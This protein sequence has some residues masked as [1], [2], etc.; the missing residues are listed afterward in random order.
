[1]KRWQVWRSKEAVK[2]AH[3]LTGMLILFL[4][5]CSASP[6]AQPVPTATPTVAPTAVPTP[7]LAPTPTSIPPFLPPL[8]V[9]SVDNAS[10]VQLLQTLPIPDF[11]SASVSQCSVAFNPDGSLLAGVCNNSTV[12]VWEVDS[13]RLRVTL[14][15]EPSHEVGIAFSPDGSQVATGGFGGE[16]RLFD[17]ASGELLATFPALR[18]PVWDLDFT[19]DG[20]WLAAANFFDAMYLWQ[21]GSG[22]QRWSYGTDVTNL[23]PLSV[24]VHPSGSPIAYG[25]AMD[26]VFILDGETGAVLHRLQ[27]IVPFGDVAFSPDGSLLAGGSD[28]DRIRL[29]S[30]DH[31]EPVATWTGHRRWVNGVAFSPDGSL[32]VSGSHDYTVGIWEV[33]TGEALNMLAG[34]E[35]VV[36]RVAVNPAGTL[37]ASI[38]WDGTVRLWGVPGE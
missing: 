36:L 27:I 18:S 32:L 29:W 9:I 35:T 19:P 33:R 25:T 31:Y 1:M 2:P 28:D 6:Q 38:S 8:E 34:H 7:T 37:I 22:E 11:S 17:T 13:G 24:D 14:L 30:T 26:G 21:V 23:S 3:L 12:P 15:D 4:A 5:A 10:K 16:I 20:E